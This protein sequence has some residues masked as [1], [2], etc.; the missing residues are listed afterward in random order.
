MDAPKTIE[1]FTNLLR[2][3]YERDF[4]GF[5]TGFDATI[6]N[7]A[8]PACFD[9][10]PVYMDWQG[11]DIDRLCAFF[12]EWYSWNP[13]VT[14]GLDYIQKFSWL[15]Y[16]NDAGADFVATGPGWAMTKYFVDLKGQWMDSDASIPLVEKWMAELGDQMNDY[17]IPPGGYRSFNQFF[18]RE[19]KPGQRPISGPT[20]SSLVV[21]PADAV[22]NMIDDNLTMSRKL[23]VK[24]QRLDVPTLLDES[25]LAREFEGGTAL[26]C[27]LMPDVYH[28][29]HAPVGGRVVESNQDVIGDVSASLDKPHDVSEGCYFGIEDFPELL[30]GGDVG[31]GYDYSVFERF[32]RGYLIIKTDHYGY[33]AM[34]PV[35]LNT[36]ASVVFHERFKRIGAEDLPQAVSKGDEIGYFKYGGSLNILLFQRGVFSSVR[37]PQGQGIGTMSPLDSDK[38]LRFPF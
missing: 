31:Y 13:D 18:I 4:K 30:D 11:A 7:L 9:D 37:I 16:Q 33:V 28:R 22:V 21:S 26:S 14:T 12:E 27:I 34:I 38:K 1:Q 36:I 35:G 2:N 23:P 19:L 5:R 32:R 25:P 10:D 15:Y 24:T 20:D 6:A 8:A 3:W 29:F 17:I